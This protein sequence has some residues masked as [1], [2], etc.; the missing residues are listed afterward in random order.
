LAQS[1]LHAGFALNDAGGY[2]YVSDADYNLIDKVYYGEQIA[3]K[4]YGRYPNGYG[5]FVYM[6]PSFVKSNY[7]GSSPV[8]DFLLYPNPASGNIYIE[9]CCDDDI[10]GY[11]IYDSKGQQVFSK[12]IDE[13]SLPDSAIIKIDIAGFKIGLYV[14]VA[15]TPN[16]LKT[17]KFIVGK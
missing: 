17:K 16:G 15:E 2:L 4:A 8:M 3:D 13:S 9:M 14:I 6:Q 1:G 5:P 12:D 7:P 10:T 11:N